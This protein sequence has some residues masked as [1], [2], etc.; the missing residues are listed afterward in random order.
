MPE[1]ETDTSLPE[2]PVAQDAVLAV[3]AVE[4]A[5]APPVEVELARTKR[6]GFFGWFAILWLVMVA[7][8]A[9]VPTLFPVADVDHRFREPIIDDEFGPRTGHWLGFDD[10]G[11]D[12]MSKVVYGTR[13]SLIVSVGAIAIGLVAGGFLGL[14]AGYF[15]GWIDTLLANAFNVMLAVP[16]LV[17]ALTLAAVL[18]PPGGD[19]TYFRRVMVV[20]LAIGLVSIPTLGRITRANTLAWSQREF[21]LAARVLGGKSARILVREVL[22]N[23]LPAMFSI[24]LLGIAVAIVVEGGLALLGVGVPAG[25]DTPSW[26]NLIATGR[27]QMLLGKPW[28]VLAPS[29]LIFVTVLCLNYLGDVV[30]ARFDVRESAL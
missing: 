28:I 2:V 5:E 6:L 7:A 4:S 17:L 25:I 30:R 11:F 14:V 15:R 1:S 9:I 13:A 20:T 16:S 21:V 8:M 10:S 19:V 18:S 23:V 29:V 27:S 3:A 22:P 24:A 26:G 12:M